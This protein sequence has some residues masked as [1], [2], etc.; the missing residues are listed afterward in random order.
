MAMRWVPNRD[1]MPSVDISELATDHIDILRGKLR[2]GL[3]RDVEVTEVEGPDRPRV[4]QSFCSALPVSYS[5]VPPAHWEPFALLVLEV[6]YEATMWAAVLNAQRGASKVVFL[7]LLGGGAFGN[8][9]SWIHAAMRRALKLITTFDLDVR[10]VSY[11][12]PSKEIVAI[13]DEFR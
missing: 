6:A 7:T 3:H 13:A 12:T 9:G 10:L 8:P 11:G 1:S 2:I 5:R 4:S